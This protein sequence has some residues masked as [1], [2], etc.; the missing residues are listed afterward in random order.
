MLKIYKYRG[1]YLKYYK[2]K[3]VPVHEYWNVHHKFGIVII[4]YNLNN[5]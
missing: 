5:E 4:L 2:F 1:L 3:V